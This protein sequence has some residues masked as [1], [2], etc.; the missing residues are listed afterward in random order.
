MTA[1]V[2]FRRD[3]RVHDHP[4]LRAALEGHER[5]VPVFCLDDRLLHGRHASGARTQFLLECLH[6]LDRSLSERGGRLVMRHGPPERELAELARSTGASELHCTQDISPFAR[7]RGRLVHAAMRELNVAIQTHPGLSVADDVRTIRTRQDRPYSVFTPFFNNWREQPRRAPLQAPRRVE[8]PSG[9]PVGR[10]PTLRSLG[11]SSDVME[12]LRGG[13]QEARR[14]L[15]RFLRDPVERYAARHDAVDQAGTSKLSP[16]LRFGCLSARAVE[17]R[18]GSGE[19]PAAFRRQLCWRDFYSHVLFHFPENAH[20]E[21]QQRY[22][23]TLAWNED[24]EAFRA[25]CAGRTGFPLVDAGMRQLAREGWMHNRAR[26][27]VG[28]FLTKDLGIDWRRGEGW[29][30]RM[31]LDGD[32]ANNNGNW[33]WIASV[34][35]DPQP[36]FRRIYNPT[37]H[38]ERYDPE[39]SYVREYVPELRDV[40]AAQLREPWLMAAELQREVGCVI[41]RDYPAPILDRRVAREHALARYKAAGSS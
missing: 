35:T 30:M 15:E 26:L 8:L 3:L 9:V 32:P 6:D 17:A 25:W 16:Y 27:V 20:Q 19:G 4:A 1:L 24:E 28:S 34:G 36:V 13:E 12:P 33:Q 41:G 5:V 2:W 10:I 18:L 37:L 23:G 38:M 29:F 14:S 39:G 7:A 22:R 31:L 40:P 21:F 11:L